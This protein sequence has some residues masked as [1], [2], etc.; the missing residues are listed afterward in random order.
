MHDKQYF[1]FNYSIISRRSQSNPFVLKLD[2]SFDWGLLSIVESP[3]FWRTSRKSLTMSRLAPVFSSHTW[4]HISAESNEGSSR[5]TLQAERPNVNHNKRLWA[6]IKLIASR[7]HDAC[8][9]FMDPPNSTALTLD[10]IIEQIDSVTSG[11]IK[12]RIVLTHSCDCSTVFRSIAPRED[13][14]CKSSFFIPNK[15]KLEHYVNAT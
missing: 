5:E 12:S 4:P 9:T 3:S 14:Y 13:L 15:V 1:I 10:S 8:N 2:G 7:P 6:V 11:W